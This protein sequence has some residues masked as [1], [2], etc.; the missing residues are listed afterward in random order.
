M[1]RHRDEVE[2]TAK[3][4]PYGTTKSISSVKVDLLQKTPIGST[5]SSGRVS[6][7]SSYNPANENHVAD[8]PIADGLR[9]G[10]KGDKEIDPPLYMP[11]LE[12]HKMTGHADESNE[13]RL[14]GY[15]KG[16]SPRNT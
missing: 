4:S 5:S 3:Q 12:G 13:T 11:E 16:T 15:V 7:A 2:A 1:T 8:P 10:T 6:S 9:G 14:S